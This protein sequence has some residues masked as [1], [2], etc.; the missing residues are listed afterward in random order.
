MPYK[1]FLS[2]TVW[3]SLPR[4]LHSNPILYPQYLVVGMATQ[5]WRA[6]RPRW[7]LKGGWRAG[8]RAEITELHSHASP[9][10]TVRLEVRSA[11][12]PSLPTVTWQMLST[13]FSPIPAWVRTELLR[14]MRRHSVLY[15]SYSSSQASAAWDTLYYEVFQVPRVYTA[16][17]AA[18][19]GYDEFLCYFQLVIRDKIG[20]LT[21]Q[22]KM[23]GHIKV[24][25]AKG[26]NTVEWATG[27]ATWLD[28]AWD[29]VCTSQQDLEVSDNVSKWKKFQKRKGKGSV[30]LGGK[31]GEEDLLQ[32]DGDHIETASNGDNDE[33]MG[34]ESMLVPR[35]RAHVPEEPRSMAGLQMN[36][37]RHR[38]D[39][40]SGTSLPVFSI[41]SEAELL[42]MEQLIG[43]E[44]RRRSRP[45]SIL[46]SHRQDQPGLSPSNPTD[47]GLRRSGQ[48]TAPNTQSQGF[49]SR[50][51][52]PQFSYPH[53]RE[54]SPSRHQTYL[55]SHMPLSISSHYQPA[56]L[57]SQYGHQPRPSYQPIG[58]ITGSLPAVPMHGYGHMQYGNMNT[59]FASDSSHDPLLSIDPQLFFSQR[60]H[61]SFHQAYGQ[62]FPPPSMMT[63]TLRNATHSPLTSAFD[64]P[65][66]S[67]GFFQP[68]RLQEFAHAAPPSPGNQAAPMTTA[69]SLSLET[70][71]ADAA[72]YDV[73]AQMME[74]GFRTDQD[75]SV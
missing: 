32:E 71:S 13:K 27:T 59:Q 49:Q 21:Q 26:H 68:T 73:D 70:S 20:N 15:W 9:T 62:P 34:S 44:P 23:D 7:M 10:S 61:P 40:L 8:A 52:P 6:T 43:P 11:I 28:D 18:E 12:D 56:Q 75:A 31:G 39:Q 16:E 66:F 55:P 46:P 72:S 47:L 54:Q 67:G 57:A 36:T 35:T 58:E 50:D 51:G 14:W 42:N 4:A 37:A 74:L 69:D 33:T 22:L 48:Y 63:N 64:Q 5:Q 3:H 17:E 19:P 30:T 2:Y 38:H 53:G 29:G 65:A 24:V 41:I 1:T 45:V 60:T 25:R